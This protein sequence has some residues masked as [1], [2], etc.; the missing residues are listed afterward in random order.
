MAITDYFISFN[1]DIG[2]AE[3]SFIL[4]I[5]ER[6]D[7]LFYMCAWLPDGLPNTNMGLCLMLQS[8]VKLTVR[9]A[10]RGFET[11]WSLR[12]FSTQ[13]IQHERN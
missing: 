9:F 5:L 1:C 4:A 12:F 3:C 11:R 8:F 6:T 7:I 13:A 2:K 10:S